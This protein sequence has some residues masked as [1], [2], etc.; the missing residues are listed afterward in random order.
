MPEYKESKLFASV[1]V[2]RAIV[3]LA[4]PAVLSQI[5]LVAYNMADTLFIGL[6]GSD[7]M[8]TAVTICMPAFMF[9]S[10][11]SNLF[12]IGGGSAI[13]RMLGKKDPKT[14]SRI[15][16]FAFW[17]CVLVT[18]LYALGSY[19]LA[20]P[21]VDLLGGRHP[22]VHG[23][24]KEYLFWTVT[25]F[26][27]C[28]SVS[29]LLSHLVRSEGHALQASIGIMFGGV[30]NI[31]LD[32]LF[33]FVILP[34]GH[35]ILGAAVATSL[36]NLLAV[37]YYLVFILTIS[38]KKKTILSIHPGSIR[39]SGKIIGEIFISGLPAC[40]MTLFENISFMILDNLMQINGIVMQAGLGVA[41]KI[42]M[43]SHSIVRGVTQGV[44]P[45]IAYNY[46]SR[47]HKRMYSVFYRSAS[48]SCILALICMAAYLLFSRFFVGLFIQSE[49]DSILYGAQF[50]RIL[51]IGCPFSALAY[52]IISFFQ[53][54]KQGG[55]ALLVA[56]SRKGWLDI[57][58]MFILQRIDPV[59]GIVSATP[60]A[61]VLCCILAVVLFLFF[62]RALKLERIVLSDP[63]TDLQP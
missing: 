4:V 61:D 19:L 10:A 12:G 55:K 27:L 56:L 40:L 43:L 6:T 26:G 17:A 15:S 1:P 34:P 22:A 9:L 7:S 54:T 16:S 23:L 58:L 41:K 8:I 50:L 18:V 60:I 51:C 32:P 35:E 2:N 45:L 29:T 13:S 53:A 20:D 11:F 38:R 25:C 48:A 24:A 47:D 28:A 59:R 49:S 21:F 52:A 31:L 39:L 36:S 3:K 46:G 33:M 14:A 62:V 44:L 30:M 37:L 5:I 63:D 42:N 57:P